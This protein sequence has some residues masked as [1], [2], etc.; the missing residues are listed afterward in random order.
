[1]TLKGRLHALVSGGAK[2]L[3]KEDPPLSKETEKTLVFVA[4][5]YL[6]H[7]TLHYVQFAYIYFSTD[8]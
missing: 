4:L 2:V 6:K 7:T 5:K 8:Y 1:M 3:S